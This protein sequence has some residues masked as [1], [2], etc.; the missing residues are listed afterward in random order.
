MRSAW[1]LA[2]LCNAALARAQPTPEP[3]SEAERL[4]NEG[5]SLAAAG[6]Y[7]GAC[8]RF[9]KSLELDHSLGT[10][11]NLADCHENLGHLREAWRLF[12][13]VAQESARSAD[14]SR[15]EFA[16]KRAAAV[17]ARLATIVIDVERP[18]IGM[19]ITVGDHPVQPTTQ[20]IDLVE[21]GPVRI[22]ASVPRHRPFET[23]VDGTAGTTQHVKIPPFV[24]SDAPPPERYERARGRV[25][26]AYGLGVGSVIAGAAGLSLALIGRSNYN[27]TA[28][29]LHCDRV[30]GGIRC[31][32]TGAEEVAE[33]QRLADIGTGFAVGGGALA[34]AA[35]VVYLTAPME[36]I[37]VAPVASAE[38]L[39]ITFSRAF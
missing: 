11:L 22:T 13:A 25:Y 38:H 28:D 4:F 21:P 2:V 37:T 26:L 39:G 17:A 6:D 16:R 15:T 9:A 34:I 10:E 32:D 35:V 33:A 24:E 20:I 30:S 7:A 19:A 29:G 8:E 5:R 27:T 1:V 3:D 12:T 14:A 31:D 36:R 23:T 18:M